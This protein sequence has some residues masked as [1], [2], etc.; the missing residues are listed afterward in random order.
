M[1]KVL[2]LVLS[3]TALVVALVAGT[4]AVYASYNPND[5][6][7]YSGGQQ[8]YLFKADPGADYLYDPAGTAYHPYMMQRAISPG[9]PVSLSDGNDTFT[10]NNGDTLVFFADEK[11]NMDVTFPSGQWILNLQRISK[12]AGVDSKWGN[13]VTAKVGYFDGSSYEWFGTF[14]HAATN[15][16]GTVD[17]FDIILP[18]DYVPVGDTLVIELTNSGLTQ[19]IRQSNGTNLFSPESDPGYPL[20]EIATGTLLGIGLAGL[21]GYIVQKKKTAAASK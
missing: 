3:I 2:V 9:D 5:G 20:P 8:W 15:T 17:T 12:G 7:F 4:T 13:F 11:A 14:A 21:V 19:E 18:S 10:F 16:T 1:K 6:E